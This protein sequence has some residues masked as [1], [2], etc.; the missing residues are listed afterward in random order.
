[1][2]KVGP[3]KMEDFLPEG[4]V[5]RRQALVDPLKY[6]FQWK[7]IEKHLDKLMREGKV[8]KDGEIYLIR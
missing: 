7:M 4:I 1:M 8:N 3:K 6:Y 2:L 5:Y